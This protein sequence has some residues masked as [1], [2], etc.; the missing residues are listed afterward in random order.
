MLRFGT[1]PNFEAGSSVPSRTG[2]H[3]VD[4]DFQIIW[5]YRSDRTVFTMGCDQTGSTD[6]IRSDY[7]NTDLGGY[8]VNTCLGE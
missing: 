1:K 4:P 7:D 8:V 6:L 3:A 2:F 5:V